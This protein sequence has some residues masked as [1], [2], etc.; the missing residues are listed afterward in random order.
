MA[1]RRHSTSP[2][3]AADSATTPPQELRC[4]LL[5]GDCAGVAVLTMAREG[6]RNAL[7]R[8]MLAQFTAALDALKFNPDVRVVI[9]QSAVPRVFCAGADLKERATMPPREVA[10]FVSGLRGAFLAVSQLPMPTIAAVE[11]AALGGGLELALACDFRV[12]G[13]DAT[14]GLPET[15]LAIIP[16]AGGTQ[17]LPRL[18]GASRAKELITGRKLSAADAQDYG[19]LTARVPSGTALR[20]ALALA[21]EILPRGPLAVRLAKEAVDRGCEVDMATGLAIEAAC[22]AQV[23]P[24]ADR[25]EGLAAF[26]EKRAPVFTGR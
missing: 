4:E 20:S 21:R 16:G 22:Y 1:S 24:S 14:F 19:L 9:L 11:G 25:L 13:E 7:G 26:R 18:I 2:A 8:V 17:R 12:G 6:A 3:T 5:D 23:I 10:A 15:G